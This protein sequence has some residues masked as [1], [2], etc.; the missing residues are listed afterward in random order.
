MQQHA[1]CRRPATSSVSRRCRIRGL[2]AGS[3]AP[4]SASRRFDRLSGGPE[5]RELL[6]LIRRKLW[7]SPEEWNAL[8]WWVAATYLEGLEREFADDEG[9]SSQHSSS[10]VDDLTDV[11]A[12]LEG[13]SV[14]AAG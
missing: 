2:A 1:I 8:P 10:Y 5:R 9:G 14:R 6:Y 11:D 3:A 13:Y 4:G 7:M 12:N